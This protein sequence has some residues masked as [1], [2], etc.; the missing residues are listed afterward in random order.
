MSMCLTREE[1]GSRLHELLVWLGAIAQAMRPALA[2]ARVRVDGIPL[3]SV[4]RP[5]PEFA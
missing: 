2:P 4:A 3:S 1:S 5:Q